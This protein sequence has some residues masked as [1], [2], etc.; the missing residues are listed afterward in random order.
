DRPAPDEASAGEV[1]PAVVWVAPRVRFRYRQRGRT[2]FRPLRE[3]VAEEFAERLQFG[4]HPAGMTIGADDFV[5]AGNATRTIEI[6][7]PEGA[8]FA[9]FAVEVQLD[10]RGGNSG[11]ARCAIAA[12]TRTSE[13]AAS[14]PVEALLADPN[15]AEFVEFRTGLLEFARN[16]PQ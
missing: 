4:R 9:E 1:G 2:D 6:P 16:L 10:T 11:V 13:A 3:L 8:R 7:V 5:L 14:R 15:S 12:T